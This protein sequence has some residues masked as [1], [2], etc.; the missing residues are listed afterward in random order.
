MSYSFVSRGLTGDYAYKVAKEVAKEEVYTNWTI[1]TEVYATPTPFTQWQ[2]RFAT[3][4]GDPSQ[5]T[6]LRVKMSLRY[7]RRPQSATT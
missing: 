6:K 4:G 3:N 7:R 5:V 1:D 2:I